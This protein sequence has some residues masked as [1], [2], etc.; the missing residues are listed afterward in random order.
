MN[1]PFHI[2]AVSVLTAAYIVIFPVAL[3]ANIFLIFIIFKRSTMKTT[4]NYLFANMAAANLLVA[5]FIMPYAVRSLF[6]ADAWF[7]GVLGQIS[8]RLLH[9]ELDCD[10]TGSVLRHFISHEEDSGYK[11]YQIYYDSHL[12]I[13]CY[14]HD[15]ILG[16]VRDKRNGCTTA[17]RLYCSRSHYD[18]NSLFF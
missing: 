18:G 10:F 4:I 15:T 7:G 5:V 2:A 8:C 17:V 9:S 11:K 16:H 1:L 12:D 14:F 3:S 13:I 6:A